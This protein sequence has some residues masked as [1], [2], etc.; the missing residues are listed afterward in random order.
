MV[1]ATGRSLGLDLKSEPELRWIV[2]RAMQAK[3]PPA[4]EVLRQGG[5]EVL[6]KHKLSGEVPEFAPTHGQ[7]RLLATAAARP[8]PASASVSQELMEDGWFRAA[9]L[10]AFE[11][12]EGELSFVEDEALLVN[13]DV[14]APEG[15]NVAA[16]QAEPANAALAPK[17][18]LLKFDF[19]VTA[20]CDF[21]GWSLGDLL[22]KKGDQLVV[23]PGVMACRGWWLGR[24][25]ECCG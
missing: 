3:V 2:L 16:R 24:L 25:G 4:W 1:E 8:W 18:Y 6:Y 13:S 9:A 22:F 15:W 12:E 5:D 10:A 11:G 7:L 21:G 23:R 20:T 19:A 17:E 14:P